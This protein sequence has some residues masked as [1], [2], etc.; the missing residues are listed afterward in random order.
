MENELLFTC[1][2]GHANYGRV[3]GLMDRIRKGQ[4][5]CGGCRGVLI[6]RGM[7]GSKDPPIRIDDNAARELGFQAG[8]RMAAL[9]MLRTAL[10]DLSLTAET[11]DAKTIALGIL[12]VE[13]AEAIATL[14]RLCTE[15]GDNDWPDN[16]SLADIIEKHLWFE[17]GLE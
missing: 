6:I 17:A 12:A 5:I 4:V 11:D 13:R 1:E 2:C 10:A 7:S 9:R 16:L 3:E 8:T 15:H 14:R